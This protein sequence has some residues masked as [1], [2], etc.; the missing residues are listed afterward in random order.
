MFNPFSDNQQK[1][2][3]HILPKQLRQGEPE[4]ESFDWAL[5]VIGGIV[6]V[7]GGILSLVAGARAADKAFCQWDAKQKK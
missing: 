7:G 3:R 5:G 1:E 2:G 4:A 6:A